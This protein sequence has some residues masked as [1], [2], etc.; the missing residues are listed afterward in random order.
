MCYFLFV[1]VCVGVWGVL[2]YFVVLCVLLLL[3]VVGLLMV[4]MLFVIGVFYEDGFVDSCDVFGGGYMCDDV[5]CI[6]YDL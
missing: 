2:V 4:V 1:G 5:L 3:I 6:M